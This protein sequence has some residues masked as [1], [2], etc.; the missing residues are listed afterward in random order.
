MHS[1]SKP[2]HT[3]FSNLDFSYLKNQGIAKYINADSKIA[4]ARYV[5]K[6]LG[7]QKEIWEIIKN[8]ILSAVLNFSSLQLFEHIR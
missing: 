6:Y 1:K 5:K 2:L 8:H 7:L 4:P 3:K